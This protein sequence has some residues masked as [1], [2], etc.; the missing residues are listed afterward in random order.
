MNEVEFDIG[1]LWR[2]VKSSWKSNIC[3]VLIF[4]IAFLSASY[5]VKS[6]Y[7][8][9]IIILPVSENQGG[10]G[11][12]SNIAAQFGGFASL[13]GIDLS[14]GKASAN[15]AI[16]K[17]REF[18]NKY[19]EENN[20]LPV[21]FDE[22]W[23]PATNNWKP[24]VQKKPPTLWNAYGYFD[25]KVR[26]ITSDPKTGLVTLTIKWKDPVVA[27]KWANELVV[28]VNA[29]IRSRAIDQAE[30]SSAYLLQEVAKTSNADMRAV[31]YKLMEKQKQAATLAQVKDEFAF[32]IIDPAVVQESKPSSHRVLFLLVGVVVGLSVVL[33]RA[34]I[35]LRL[36]TT[37]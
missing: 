37:A 6:F 13:A 26:T 23:D 14:G 10:G 16:L 3:L 34:M 19:I 11:V 27:A 35:T 5:F 33:F 20:L 31:L 7:R 24:E 32:Q 22:L 36:Q 8:A 29:Y 17:S 9:E 12:L 15:I 2:V 25:S 28:R 18:T 30:K 4:C 21:L 1:G